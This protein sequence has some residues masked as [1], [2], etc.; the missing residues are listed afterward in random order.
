MAR[1]HRRRTG[2]DE[3]TWAALRRLDPLQPHEPLHA[4]GWVPVPPPVPQDG[5]ATPVRRSARH[6]GGLADRLPVGLRAAVVAPGGRAVLG[7]VL[8]VGLAA[9][10]AVVATWLARPRVEPLPPRR[11]LVGAPL[12]LTPAASPSAPGAS[13]GAPAPSSSPATLLVHV[14]GAVREPGLVEL[15]AGSRV[16]DAVRAAG[17]TTRPAAAASVNLARPVVDGEQVVVLRR[18]DPGASTAGLAVGGPAPSGGSGG[19]AGTAAAPV[20]LNAATLDQLDTL[21]GIGPVLAQRIL[22]WRTANGRF[23]TVDEL[24]E[25]SG[26]GE[27]TLSDLRPVVTV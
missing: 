2:Q 13:A 20:D 19:T 15:P 7:I 11:P 10:A 4:S 16:A 8:L 3:P 21:P 5:K 6:L 23:S 27:A 25:V 9:A 1:P 12:A 18:G 26:I 14:A 17:G 22:D 24:N